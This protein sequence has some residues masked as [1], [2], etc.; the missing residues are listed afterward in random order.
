MT[1]RRC[2]VLIAL[3]FLILKL[4]PVFCVNFL[5]WGV[6]F[7]SIRVNLSHVIFKYVDKQHNRKLLLSSFV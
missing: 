6:I 2:F 5:Y 7:P 1:T 4:Y 3:I